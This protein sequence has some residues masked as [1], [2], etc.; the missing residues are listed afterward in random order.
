MEYMKVPESRYEEV[1]EYLR[2]AFPDEPLNVAI[3]LCQKG[4]PCELLE[5]QDLQTL[6]D[7]LSVMVIDKTTGEIAGV[8][9][10]GISRKGDVETAMEAMKDID[11]IE[12][13]HIFELLF[14]LNK[15]ADLFN[16]YKVDKIFEL[17][18]LSV[19]GKYRGRGIAKELFQRSEIVAE[20]SGFKLIKVDATSFFTQKIAESVGLKTEAEINYKEFED[21][22]GKRIYY[23]V[24]SPHDYYKLMVKEL[25]NKK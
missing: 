21:N 4:V 7:G 6:R 3:G 5:S 11:S 22:E 17:R 14:G 8:A 24:K 1:I 2:E 9:L 15:K 19:D 18:I 20:E 16:K 12:Y 23:K 13:H 10:N 25:G